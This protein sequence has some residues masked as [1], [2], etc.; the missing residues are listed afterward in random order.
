MGGH[1]TAFTKQ[2]QKK[3]DA[4]KSATMNK[5]A[6]MCAQKNTNTRWEELTSAN[7]RPSKYKRANMWMWAHKLLCAVFGP[8][9][10][11]PVQWLQR[12]K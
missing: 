6:K 1:T 7:T 2:I 4:H 8:G 5:G 12:L 3:T 10:L 9:N 11:P